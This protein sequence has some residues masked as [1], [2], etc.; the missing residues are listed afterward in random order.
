MKNTP[1]G[2]FGSF[3]SCLTDYLNRFSDTTA[4]GVFAG[5]N[6]KT[7]QRWRKQ[8]PE[9]LRAIRTKVFLLEIGYNLDCFKEMPQQV[10]MVGMCL[11][12]GSAQKKKSTSMS[13]P[14]PAH[15]PVYSTGYAL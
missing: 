6:A 1:K 3:Q 2:L 7:L 12:Y 11:A 8:A 4:L 14:S 13:A 15:S 10:R 5:V 9:G